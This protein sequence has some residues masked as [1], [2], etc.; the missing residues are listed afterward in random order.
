LIRRKEIA[1]FRDQAEPPREKIDDFFSYGWALVHT[2]SKPA[3]YA[4]S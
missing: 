3:E 2:I 1:M 4:P